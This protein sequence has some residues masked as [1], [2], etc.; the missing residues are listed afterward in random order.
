[1]LVE[2]V[3][4]PPLLSE[5]VSGSV[6]W[7][8]IEGVDYEFVGYFLSCHLIIEHYL[9]EYLRIIHPKLRWDAVRHTFSQKV[10]LLSEFKIGD[11]Y[12]CIPAFKH[13]NSLRNKL[14]HDIQFKIRSED[15]LPLTQYL[16]GIYE[17]RTHI[18]TEPKAILESFTSMSCVLFASYI[19]GF[20]DSLKLTV[21]PKTKK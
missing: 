17:D 13:M 18:P 20:A 9:D 8:K 16:A 14:T 2:K 15:L 11:K 6:S 10:A 19:S 3:G 7:Q 12:D 5:I 21:P 1:M 4:L